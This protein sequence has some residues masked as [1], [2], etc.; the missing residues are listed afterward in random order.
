M[1]TAR[2][3]LSDIN[4]L[5][6]ETFQPHLDDLLA[7]PLS[8]ENFESWLQRWSE[9]TAVLKETEAQVYREVT[10]NTADAEAEKR[11][12]ILVE[13]IRPR[14]RVVN[15]ALKQKLLT[16][17]GPVSRDDLKL[18]LLRFRTEV[19]IFRQENVPL[20][21]QLEKLANQYRKI[22]GGLTIEW[23][24]QTETIP[25]AQ[26]HLLEPDRARREQVWRRIMS[27]YAA[28]RERL[29]QLYL[30][31]LTLRRQVARNA[32]MA[33]FRDYCWQALARFDYT[34]E[35]CLTFHRAIELEVVP[36][37]SRLYA[38]LAERLEVDTLRPWDVHADPYGEPLRPFNQAQELE[39]GVQRML[40]H[41]DPTLARYFAVMRD[42]FLDLA[43]RPN[44]A[45]GGYCS[46]FPVSRKPYIFMNA[47]GTHRDV[48]TLLHESG[49]S[50]HFLESARQPLVWNH[51]GPMEFCEVASMAM[52]LLAAPY[53]SR[54][55]GGFYDE[56]DARRAYADLLRRIVFFLPYMAVV[57]AFQQ[58]VYTDAPEEVD[59]DQLDQKWSELWDRFM[60]DIDYSGLQAEKAGGWQRK[61][62]IFTSPF[63]YIEY[64]LAQLGAL[65]VWRNALHD[66][67][68]AVG[69]YRQAL[70][71]GYTRSLPELFQAA[72]VRFAF[73]RRTVS[74]VMTLIQ[75]QLTRLAA[76]L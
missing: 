35:D 37:A 50:F 41:L 31:M 32:G 68:Q 44:K 6:W 12:E 57:D 53:L 59:A 5:N 1:S 48:A 27:R 19:N 73:D 58:W 13:E 42:G 49:H 22:I 74:E 38:E 4:P 67:T 46:T 65:Q 10:E 9:L 56:R 2:G 64:G 11:F 63:Y 28:E 71:L 40:Q 24:G 43:S 47:V 7:T 20:E 54:E 39:E 3:Y 75:D 51:N 33:N 29:N 36:L 30:Q 76:D 62:H 70:A 55:R 66:R 25:Q 61:E 52:E 45:P 18:L 14:F 17:D 72:G 16:V 69:R 60:P 8:R 34:P 15:Q 23:E 26:S 21:S